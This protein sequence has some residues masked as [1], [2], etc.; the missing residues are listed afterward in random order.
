VA[1]AAVLLPVGKPPSYAA[2]RQPQQAVTLAQGQTAETHLA[3]ADRLFNESFQLWRTSQFEP[4]FNALLQALEL[5]RHPDVQA[6][7]PD[8][9][10][11]GEG[12]TLT[13]LGVISHALGRYEQALRYHTDALAISQAVGDRAGEGTTLNNIGIVYYSLGQ[14]EQALIYYTDA[15]V[16]SQAMGD[17]AGE[18]T[19]LNN[20]GVVH[21]NLAQYEQALRYYSDALAIRQEVGDHA[22]EGDTLNN[23]GI[24]YYNLGQYEQAL[25]YYTDA[26]VISQAMGDRAGEGTTLNNIG[27]VHYN[28]AQYEQA[29]RYYSDA[30]AIRQAVGD[31]A[32]VGQTLHNIG[33]VYHNLG[34]YEQALGYY[35]DSLAIAQE[36]RNRAG[37]GIT[38]N[39]IGFVLEGLDEPELAIAFF[40]QAVNVR[41]DI[42]G[43]I[44]GLT[45]EQQ[46]SFTET[47]AHTYRRLADLL[48]QAD[49]VLEA[50]RVL[51]LLQVQELD[52]YLQDV[53][54]T[55]QTES[56]VPLRPEEL[57]ALER[58][59]TNQDQIVAL[60]RGLRELETIAT[61]NRTPE[62]TARIRELRQ[63]QQDARFAFEQ[64]ITSH[65]VQA[66]VERLRNTTGAANLELAE[67]NQLQNNLQT[68]RQNTVALYPLILE[69]RLELVVVTANAPPVS[70]TVA[71]GREELNRAIAEFRS[72]LGSPR[73]DAIVPAQQLYDWLIRP[74]EADLAQANAEV[75]LYAPDGQLRYIPLAALHDGESWLAQRLQVNNIVAASLTNLTNRPFSGGLSVLAAAFTEGQFTIPTS[76]RTLLF[77]GLTYAGREVE[78]IAQLIPTT[79]QRLNQDFAPSIVLDMNDYNVIHLATHASFNPGPPEDSFIVFGDGSH[80]TLRDVG[81]W[82]FPNVDL[83]VLSAC[84]TAV[85]DIIDGNGAEILGLGY[86]MKQAGADAAIASL[87][88]VSDGGTQMLMDAFYTN[89]NQGISKTEA[90]QRAQI[91]LIEGDFTASGVDRRAGIDVVSKQTGLPLSVADSLSHPYY[92]APFILIGNGL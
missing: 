68:L 72:A 13:G 19:T 1:L 4:A 73:R 39:N 22:G 60:G 78:N 63:L 62:Q 47:V 90:L 28:L 71:V 67:L 18:G 24:V 65:E 20:I 21:Y 89:L 48:L 55:A 70:R 29:L 30:L 36:V 23:I 83:V 11:Q 51:D 87:W 92:W 38:L 6:A 34:Q 7:F 81:L 14:Y 82:N 27:V 32:G 56:G 35:T 57:A 80:V 50:Q 41:E 76:T 86:R 74:I 15:L 37:E 64:L 61:A 9:S 43:D 66:L 2:T 45:A 12:Q 3:E 85:G 33:G 59:T 26:L 91:A 52:D 84:E 44:R 69:D 54:R 25:I 17:R 31:R 8:K 49:R 42:R 79:T 88:I 77:D 5:Y 16:I 53:Q 46:Q 40:K 58:F 75:V 10:R